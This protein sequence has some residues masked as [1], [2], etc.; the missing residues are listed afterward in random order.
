MKHYP[1]PDEPPVYISK[2]VV[3]AD[4]PSF[5][6]SL[7]DSVFAGIGL[8]LTFW[9]AGF[10]FLSGLE[11]NWTSILL[12]IIF[13]LT[14]T[15]LALP[16]LHQIFTTMYLPDYFMARTKTGDG[17]L[18][19]PINLAVLGS[20]EDIHAAM[21]RADWT[22]ADEITLRSA[23]GIVRS[24]LTGKSYPEAPVSSLYLFGNKQDFAYQQEV[25]GNA[26]QRHHVRFW[27]VPE[28]WQLPGGER[29]DWL[30]GGTYDKSVGVSTM[31]LQITHKIDADVDAER[32]YIIDTVRY[33]DPQC[34]VRVIEQFSTSFYDRNGGGDAVQTDGDLPILDV[35]GA[36]DRAVKAGLEPA[37][38]S[39]EDLDQN[40]VLNQELPP[41]QFALV[42]AFLGIEAVIAVIA[43]LLG[44]AGQINS[45]EMSTAG[46]ALTASIIQAI[47]LFLAIR[48]FNWARLLLLT[49]STIA[50][51]IGLIG[52]TIGELSG[53]IATI[54]VGFSV[55]LVLAFSANS[56]RQWSST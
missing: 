42:G 28:G 19:D 30:A 54:Q 29:V 49:L 47:L 10:L 50:A 16:R 43:L 33:Q 7:L 41:R 32:D 27:K 11:F 20:E 9:F 4:R 5:I 24:S 15:Y 52:L 56:V 45:E 21:R 25:D 6:Y 39:K 14:L 51:I 3:V 18:G 1:V 23:L 26:S 35:S 12:L 40:D 22:Q 17:L 46:Y 48:R 37:R 13:W 44:L 38:N 53:I 2:P 36:A 34:E 31:T 55:L 8:I